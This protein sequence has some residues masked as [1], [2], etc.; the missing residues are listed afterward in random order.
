MAL[1]EEGQSKENQSPGFAVERTV[2]EHI[3]HEEQSAAVGRYKGLREAV[4]CSQGRLGEG[5]A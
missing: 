1:R 3:D 4:A 5:E 2:M